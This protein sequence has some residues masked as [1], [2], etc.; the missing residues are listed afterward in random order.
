[1]CGWEEARLLRRASLLVSQQFTWMQSSLP[2][3]SSTPAWAE[4]VSV[5]CRVETD[6]CVAHARARAHLASTSLTTETTLRMH[7]SEKAAKLRYSIRKAAGVLFEPAIPLP[8]R[9]RGDEVPC[10]RSSALQQKP[11]PGVRNH[12]SSESGETLAPNPQKRASFRRRC[13][14]RVNPAYTRCPAQV[15]WPGLNSNNTNTETNTRERA[16][17]S[18]K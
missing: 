16:L 5:M 17:L 14:T 8:Q 12:L 2:G 6:I 18:C 11:A 4:H 10:A 15:C 1:M 3:T 9:A 7:A 13:E